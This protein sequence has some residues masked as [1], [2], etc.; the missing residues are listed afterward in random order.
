MRRALQSVECASFYCTDPRSRIP[1]ED[2]HKSD[3]GAYWCSAC[4]PRYD[5]MQHGAHHGYPAMSFPPYAVQ[6]GHDAWRLL[7][8][9]GKPACIES[10]R[11]VLGLDEDE[12]NV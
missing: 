2:A 4:K 6:Q 1:V 8:G 11:Q 10:W 12:V 7:C 5:L 9:I 3:T